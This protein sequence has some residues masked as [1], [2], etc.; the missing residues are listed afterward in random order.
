MGGNTH[1]TQ[2]PVSI[3]RHLEAVAINEANGRAFRDYDTTLI[4]I[5]N[6]VVMFV[7]DA[8]SPCDVSGSL[9]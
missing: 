9:Y 8:E 4:N 3:C 5:A 7:N 6:D 1:F 2:M